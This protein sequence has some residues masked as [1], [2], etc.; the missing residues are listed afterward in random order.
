[1]ER[2]RGT[3]LIPNPIFF[4]VVD[5]LVEIHGQHIVGV[6]LGLVA[7][8]DSVTEFCVMRSHSWSKKTLVDGERD[9][10]LERGGD[11]EVR[12]QERG[13]VEGDEDEGK[14]KVE[15][16]FFTDHL[17]RMMCDKCGQALRN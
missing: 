17:Q 13:D 7:G 15:L 12:D 11:V 3:V 1:M 8:H 5:Q 16:D 9:E 4:L 10:G 14:G 6:L 2:E